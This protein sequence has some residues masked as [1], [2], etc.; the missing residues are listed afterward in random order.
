MEYGGLCGESKVRLF[1]N[2]NPKGRRWLA[3][4]VSITRGGPN[5]TAGLALMKSFLEKE[6]LFGS[7]YGS[8]TIIT[9]AVEDAAKFVKK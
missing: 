1:E 9:Q 2:M 7:V 8:D 6:D 5:E 4:Y 3:P